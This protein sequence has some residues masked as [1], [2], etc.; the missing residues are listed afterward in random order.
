MSSTI[1]TSARL[2]R[3]NPEAQGI[4]TAAITAFLDEIEDRAIRL[5][6]L[7]IVR[8]GCVIAEGW[9]A[10][11][12]AETPHLLYSLSKS[13]TSSAIGMAIAEGLFGLDDKV[14][15]FFPDKLPGEPGENLLAMTIRH[16]LTM[17][18]GQV[19]ADRPPLNR[20]P[21]AD[22]VRD[23]L[24]TPTPLAP[25][26]KFDYST[27]AT[28]MCS[29]ILRR[30]SG[31]DLRDYLM[32]R[33][34]EPLG[35]EEPFWQRSTDGTSFG[36][37]GLFVT[38]ETI[39]KF[40]QLY[41]Q[42]GRWGGRQLVPQNWIALATS[43][44]IDNGSGGE[45]DWEQGYGFQFWMCRHGAYR[46]DGAFGQYCIVHPAQQLVVAITASVE[47]M[48]EVM[49]CVWEHVLPH[50]SPAALAPGDADGLKARLASLR[51][52]GPAGS[53]HAPDGFSGATYQATEE[54]AM[55]GSWRVQ[56]SNDGVEFVHVNG[57]IERSYRAGYRNWTPCRPGSDET[58]AGM[59]AWVSP[60]QL[61]AEFVALDSPIR[62]T[63]D[64]AFDGPTLTMTSTRFGSFEPP[65]LPV[66]IGMRE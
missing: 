61:R 30:V 54:S 19:E 23:F 53:L 22:W 28:F 65:D 51:L 15:S 60:G 27:A 62:M 24:A 49:D 4:P 39:A 45:S 18:T 40:G 12:E 38:T 34:F 56:S 5:H 36:G 43:K 33:L 44:Q 31:I 17:S 37:S 6:S 10:P 8:H 41:L 59:A 20:E 9:W 25:G 55:P 46:G 66:F 13:F 64:L 35:I 11:Y 48:Q 58:N 52:A 32:P 2:P 29:A 14:A 26:S 47:N 7:M 21:D 1:T 3:S 63:R 57:S 42:K 16:L 50:L